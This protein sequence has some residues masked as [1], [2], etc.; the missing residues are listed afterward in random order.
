VSAHG[1]IAEIF[2]RVQTGVP[3][4]IRRL[5]KP[6]FDRIV[7]EIG[8]DSECGAIK[9]GRNGGLAWL[10]SGR[11]KYVLTHE[12]GPPRDRYQITRMAAA[13]PNGAGCLF[14]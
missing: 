8:Q 2:G 11:W 1:F 3:G 9:N 7:Y 13:E 5:T 4:N 14:T 6:Q 10:P 12:P